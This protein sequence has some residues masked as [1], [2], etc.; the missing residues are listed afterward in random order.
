M[1]KVKIS[2]EDGR[3]E[4][5]NTLE[6]AA[7]ALR[8]A[9]PS[10]QRMANGLA[11][12]LLKA[13]GI[14]SVELSASKTRNGGVRERNGRYHVKCTNE[15]TGEV[16]MAKTL[17]EAA[18]LTHWPRTVTALH[19]A[20]DRGEY[21]HGWK[22]DSIPLAIQQESFRFTEK[23]QVPEETVAMLYRMARFLLITWTL[24]M[25]TKE[26]C[27]SYA[28]SHTASEISE[29]KFEKV[30]EKFKSYETWLWCR[31]RQ[32]LG[33]QLHKELPWAT[34]RQ[35]KPEGLDMTHEQWLDELSPVDEHDMAFLHDLP[36]RLRPLAE[37]LVAGM[38]RHEIDRELGIDEHA[39]MAMMDELREWYR[40]DGKDG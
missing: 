32:W 29:G 21:R 18:E 12:T 10:I 1:K 23:T 8:C 36:E 22:Y 24:P 4:Q 26:D 6:A 17:K 7:K 37:C 16:I 25:A 38:N 2:Y 40:R 3:Q 33:K 9:A 28:V 14:K 20:C 5:F 27:V 30:K 15:Q 34:L 35:E 13:H 31:I 39:R 11:S 19:Y